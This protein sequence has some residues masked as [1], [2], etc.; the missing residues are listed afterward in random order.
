[1]E[2]EFPLWIATEARWSK[3]WRIVSLQWF[4]ATMAK[5]LKGRFGTKHTKRLTCYGYLVPR[6]EYFFLFW[7]S[8]S[9]ATKPG[10]LERCDGAKVSLHVA[11]HTQGV[12]PLSRE[13]LQ[14][15]MDFYHLI[16]LLQ[17]A[18]N[19]QVFLQLTGLCG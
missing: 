2:V 4:G 9:A 16:Y 8:A 5:V 3:N 13:P 11:S 17:K 18:P 10:R 7:D 15:H 19:E 14:Y 12:S 6:E 1:M